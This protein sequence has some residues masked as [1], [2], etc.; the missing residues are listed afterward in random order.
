MTAIANLTRFVREEAY[1][2][3]F[4]QIGFS[5]AMQLDEEARHLETW[6]HNDMH[7]TMSWMEGHFDMRIDPTKLVPGAKSVIS[8]LRVYNPGDLQW[9]DTK[10]R[11]SSYALGDDYHDVMRSSMRDLFNYI[12]TTVGDVNGRVFTD[13]APVMDKAWA[14]KSGVGW[15]GKNGN[16]L[17]KKLGSLFFI[18]EIIVDIPFHYDGITT[19]H[20]GSCTRCIDA[21]PTQ[22]ITQPYVVD[23]RKCISYLTIEL[24]DAIPEMYHEQMGNWM[25]GCDVCQDVCPWN[26]KAPRTT[27]ERFLPRKELLEMTAEG[28]KALDVETYKKLFKGSAAKRTKYPG[29]VRNIAIAAKNS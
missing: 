8:V 1:R 12:R 19:D 25:Y 2:L 28:W 10:P 6:L 9:P 13:S 24:R 15:L 11:I 22:A 29:L 17:N 4:E 18:G 23:A 14:V 20:C 26:T 7:G 3:G 16:V 5:R 21:C 27:E